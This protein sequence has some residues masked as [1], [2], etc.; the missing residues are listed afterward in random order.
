MD[1]ANENHR[2]RRVISEVDQSAIAA[3][4]AATPA[5]ALMPFMEAA[6][7]LVLAAAL[8]VVALEEPAAVALAKAAGVEVRV[9]P[10]QT[11]R[12]NLSC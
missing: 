7:V 9:T 3:K 2:I 8:E 5:T 4:R 12:V 6:L 11:R 10:Y 1:E